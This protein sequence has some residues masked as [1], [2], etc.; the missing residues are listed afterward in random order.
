MKHILIPLLGILGI[1]GVTVMAHSK[2]AS[3]ATDFCSCN[4]QSGNS[5]NKTRI[6]QS[7]PAGICTVAEDVGG[8][9][10]MCSTQQLQVSE[11]SEVSRKVAKAL[12]KVGLAMDPNEALVTGGTVEPENWSKDQA[13]DIL[14][15]LLGLSLGSDADRLASVRTAL[16]DN[17]GKLWPAFSKPGNPGQSITAGKYH[18]EVGYGCIVM[19][20]GTFTVRTRT[21]FADTDACST[22]A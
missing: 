3:A 4:Q 18:A 13:P 11:D 15:T 20:D 17:I 12:G 2:P 22:D 16:Q 6:T 5:S 19:R 21:P 14:T 9:T 8:G 10:N 7:G 1:L